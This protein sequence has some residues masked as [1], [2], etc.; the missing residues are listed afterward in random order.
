MIDKKMLE[1]MIAKQDAK[2]E[3]AFQNY[4]ETGMGRYDTE[5]RNAEDMA[6]ALR[7]AYNAKED[8]DK[9]VSLN[10]Q[11]IWWAGEAEAAQRHEKLP[12]SVESL[13]RDIVAYAEAVC[14]Y[15]PQNGTE[16]N[17]NG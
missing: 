2:A 16:E 1:K 10:A 11:I 12:P 6:E 8:H 5:R 13:L 4:Q 3:K 17:D 14:H 7:V 15:K 9:M